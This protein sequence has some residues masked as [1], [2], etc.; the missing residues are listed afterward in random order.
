ML[1]QSFVKSLGWEIAP[2]DLLRFEM[3]EGRIQTIVSDRGERAPQTLNSSIPIRLGFDSLRNG[4]VDA[5]E[6]R[7]T[8]LNDQLSRHETALGEISSLSLQLEEERRKFSDLSVQLESQQVQIANYQTTLDNYAARKLRKRFRA[9]L[10]RFAAIWRHPRNRAKRKSYRNRRI[11]LLETGGSGSSL[12]RNVQYSALS[13]PDSAGHHGLVQKFMGRI[14]LDIKDGKYASKRG[15]SRYIY[16]PP[17]KPTNFVEQIENMKAKPSFSIVVPAYNTPIDLMKKLISSVQSQWYPHWELVIVDDASPEPH[18]KEFV[19]GLKDSRIK[20]EWAV[21]NRGIAD[22]TNRAIELSGGDYIVLLDHD[23]ELTIDCLY[24]LALCIDKTGA[25]YVYSDE[26]KIDLDGHHVMPHFKPDWSPDT[27]MSTMYVCHVSCIKRSLINDIGGFRSE[28]NGCQDW[29]LIL[30]LTE[31]TDKIAHVPKV[32]YHWRIIPGSVSGGLTEKPYVLDASKRVREEALLRRGLEGTL[33]PIAELPGYFTVRYKL[34]YTPIVSIVI[35]TRDNMEVLER[36]IN[37]L[38]KNAT[39]KSL[40]I[41][42]VNNGSTQQKTI[43]YF[44]RLREEHNAK[45]ID[46]DT[47][48]NFS[49]L[50]NVGAAHSSGDFLLFLND[51]TEV[52]TEDFVERMLGFAGLKHVGA[53]GAKLLYPQTDKVQHSGVL[54]LDNGP[55]H[56]FLQL[57]SDAPGYFNRNILEY[58]WL[59]VTGACMMIEKKKFM[60]VSGFSEDLPVAYNDVD[61]C[62]KLIDAG[63]F[64]VVCQQAKLYHHESVSR[65]LD[66]ASP[67]KRKRLRQ[68]LLK[69]YEKNPKYYRYDPFYNVNLHPNNCYFEYV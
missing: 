63:Y 19:E 20:V 48:F 65:G 3:L 37:S 15:P 42:I 6:G 69:F 39:Y 49:Y 68:D 58:N 5:L 50:C 17:Q 27:M 67:K 46:S 31:E 9:L 59:A 33:E 54:N 16:V 66:N 57:P 18:Y 51:D 40:E 41:I 30:R 7:L 11:A 26:D 60:H 47:P 8:D 1:F 25:D 28:F 45:I 23:D 43:S 36:C 4:G 2:D 38:V 35:P 34:G 13:S 14:T 62:C 64:N 44:D 55:G 21:S 32:L 24:E 61:I 56:A 29:D 52:L 10:V 53:V 12:T 22:A